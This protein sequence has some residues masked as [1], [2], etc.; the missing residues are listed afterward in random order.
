MEQ[1]ENDKTLMVEAVARL[2]IVD[3]AMKE[4][5]IKSPTHYY[6]FKT[7]MDYRQAILQARE[8]YRER[9]T[10]KAESVLDKAFDDFLE[11]KKTDAYVPL[12]AAIK[13]AAANSTRF[14]EPKEPAEINV[15]LNL[16][17]RAWQDEQPVLVGS[18]TTAVSDPLPPI[19]AGNRELLTAEPIA[20]PDTDDRG[21]RGSLPSIGDSPTDSLQ[22]GGSASTSPLPPNSEPDDDYDWLS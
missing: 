4:V 15:T 6:H 8:R 2:G 7:D 16:A 5:G 22:I 18:G 11:D 20:A 13:I 21:L 3:K 14:R 9:I 19:E 12:H 10:E 17:E 1:T